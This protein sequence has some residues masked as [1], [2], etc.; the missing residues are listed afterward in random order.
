[1]VVSLVTLLCA[2]ARQAPRPPPDCPWTL[3]PKPSAGGLRHV[4]ARGRDR[5]PIV[6]D[7]WERADCV[8]GRVPGHSPRPSASGEAGSPGAE[9]MLPRPPSQ[10][11]A[12]EGSL[13]IRRRLWYGGGQERTSDGNVLSDC[14][15]RASD[16]AGKFGQVGSARGDG[17]HDQFPAHRGA[18]EL[19]DRTSLAGTRI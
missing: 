16:R 5:Q 15:G 8:T 19:R 18:G 10:V 12:L 6:R 13:P 1:M 4:M 7:D 14:H 11:T 3:R 2:P 9:T 17:G